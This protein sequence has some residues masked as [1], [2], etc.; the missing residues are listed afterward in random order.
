[1][2]IAI[3]AIVLGA[4]ALFSIPGSIPAQATDYEDYRADPGTNCRIIE[5]R[6]TNRWGDDVTIRRRICG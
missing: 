3:T 4:V 5:I 1:M 2:K 6:T